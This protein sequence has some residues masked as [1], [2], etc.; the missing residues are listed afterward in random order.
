VSDIHFKGECPCGA[1]VDISGY[2][3]SAIASHVAEWNKVHKPHMNKIAQAVEANRA[4][5]L[6]HYP[7]YPWTWPTPP[8]TVTNDG[9]AYQQT[10]T[11]DTASGIVRQQHG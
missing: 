8:W 4:N 9:T 2:T 3:S 1:K 6:A 5:P 10:F 7:Y 11:T